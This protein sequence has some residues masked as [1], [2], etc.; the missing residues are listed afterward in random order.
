MLV[1]KS[2]KFRL[3]LNAQQEQQLIQAAGC[4]RFVWNAAKNILADGQAVLACGATAKAVNTVPNGVQA[5]EPTL[6]GCHS[7]DAGTAASI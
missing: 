6:V 3:K 5:Q 2:Y 7:F 4:N 1:R